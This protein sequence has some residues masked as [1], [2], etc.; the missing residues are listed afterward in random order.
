MICKKEKHGRSILLLPFKLNC[1]TWQQQELSIVGCGGWIS[2]AV[3]FIWEWNRYTCICISAHIGFVQ[4]YMCKFMWR[5]LDIHQIN[6]TTQTTDDGIVLKPGQSFYDM[7][8]NCRLPTKPKT[9]A[10]RT[11]ETLPVSSS[12]LPP[13][14]IQPTNAVCWIPYRELWRQLRVWSGT[15]F[16]YFVQT[17]QLSESFSHD[18]LCKNGCV[19]YNSTMRSTRNGRHKSGWRTWSWWHTVMVNSTLDTIAV[20]SKLQEMDSTTTTSTDSKCPAVPMIC[21]P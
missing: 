20:S 11:P 2:A 3:Q 18:D 16:T 6:F 4:T 8:W 10:L 7:G 21:I 17:S 19:I 12:T 13:S 9:T 1:K 14:S 15:L 5:V